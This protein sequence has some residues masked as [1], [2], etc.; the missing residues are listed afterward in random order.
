MYNDIFLSNSD[1]TNVSHAL[2]VHVHKKDLTGIWQK[3]NKCLCKSLFIVQLLCDLKG[4]R[5]H[6]N[7]Y[8]VTRKL[9]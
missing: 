6:P 5:H 4:T 9:W 2:G 1:L 7:K 3:R 8:V